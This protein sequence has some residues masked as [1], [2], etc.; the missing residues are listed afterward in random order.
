MS[1]RGKAIY[2]VG[3]GETLTVSMDHLDTGARVVVTI[4]GKI[5]ES[6]ERMIKEMPE[7]VGNALDRMGY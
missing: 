5:D 1:P 4:H 6:V 3:E 7:V 2:L